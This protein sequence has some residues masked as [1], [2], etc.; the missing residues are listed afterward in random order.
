MQQRYAADGTWSMP[1]EIGPCRTWPIDPFCTCFAGAD[2]PDQPPWPA[3]LE[4]CVEIATEYLWRRTAGAF[5]LCWELVRPCPA[6]GPEA[7]P[8]GGVA[9][10]DPHGSAPPSAGWD[11]G[12]GLG[13]FQPSSAG[14]GPNTSSSSWGAGGPGGWSG[15]C[16]C[17]GG[18][19]C[20]PAPELQLPGPVWQDLSRDYPHGRNYTVDVFMDGVRLDDQWFRVLDGGHVVSVGWQWPWT[21]DLS[22]P[23]IP[24][25]ESSPRDLTGTWGIRYWRGRPI[26]A[27]GVY[28]VTVLACELWKACSGDNTCKLPRGVQDVQREGVS[29]TLVDQSSDLLGNL[30]EVN[31]WVQTVN[32]HGIKEQSYVVS[33]DLSRWQG[34]SRLAGLWPPRGRG[35]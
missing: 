10:P 1:P 7:A 24:E 31:A 32:P 4:R 19:N 13:P 28:A 16:G 34:E 30:P 26:P 9:W 22:R 17:G 29:Y 15:L 18:C 33:P 6:P 25:P 2:V 20:G 12:G 8:R 27:A 14:R 11:I 21:Q 3:E 5:G 35:W 23:A